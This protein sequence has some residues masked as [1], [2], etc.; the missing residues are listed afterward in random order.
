MPKKENKVIF[1]LKNTHYAV[2]TENEDGTITYGA[3][4]PL[5][6]SVELALEPR[7]EMVEFHADDIVYYADPTNNGYEGTLTLA[8][9][10]EHFTRDVLGETH[11]EEDGVIHEYAN[12]RGKKFALLFEFDGDQTPIRHLIYHCSASRPTVGSTTKSDTKE[13]TTT[14]LSFVATARPTDERVKTKTHAQTRAEI[15]DAW[16]TAVYEKVEAV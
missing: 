5:P 6:G 1:G 10:P 12:A 3:P 9:V 16:Y 2:I 13:V 15:Y 8:R 14:E 11:D 4:V 7:G